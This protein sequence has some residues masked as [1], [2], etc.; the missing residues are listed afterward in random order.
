MITVFVVGHR[1]L[2]L[3]GMPSRMVLC[4][5]VSAVVTIYVVDV[6]VCC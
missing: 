4:G 2:R 5:H 6:V 3:S 1:V